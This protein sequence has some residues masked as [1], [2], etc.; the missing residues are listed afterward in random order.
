M[1]P[2]SHIYTI[3]IHSHPYPTCFALFEPCLLC[4]RTILRW[5]SFCWVSVGGSEGRIAVGKYFEP[6]NGAAFGSC[7]AASGW[8]DPCIRCF[9]FSLVQELSLFGN[10]LCH[11]D[12]WIDLDLTIQLSWRHF[13]AHS[14]IA[15]LRYPA[16]AGP[17]RYQL[18]ESKD[19][20]NL[21]D[22][23]CCPQT[24]YWSHLVLFRICTTYILP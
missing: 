4:P 12:F 2:T 5:S 14:G 10:I 7:L 16:W 24:F 6:V 3:A 20:W 11:F 18:S 15:P 13:S 1:L 17:L 9:F 23:S 19:V 8:N 21:D 22:F